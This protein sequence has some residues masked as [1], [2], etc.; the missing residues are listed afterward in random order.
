MAIKIIME[1]YNQQT[2]EQVAYNMAYKKVK[3]IKR[4]YTHLLVYI[5][6]NIMIFISN[7]QHLDQ[8]ESYFQFRNFTTAFFWGIG[9]LAH[10]F[11]TFMPNFIFGQSWEDRKMKEFME[12]DKKMNWK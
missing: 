4:F 1:N 3:K 12:N 11:S 10:A 2:E 7:V 9:L 8:G 5:V 6:I